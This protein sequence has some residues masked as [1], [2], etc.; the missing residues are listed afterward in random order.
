MSLS[1][2]NFVLRAMSEAGQWIEDWFEYSEGKFM[3]EHE[4]LHRDENRNLI[5]FLKVKST[6]PDIDNII[7]RCEETMYGAKVTAYQKFCAED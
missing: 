1:E 5:C 3:F 6:V 7:F 4:D 2:W